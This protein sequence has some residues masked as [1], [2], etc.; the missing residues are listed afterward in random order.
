[1]GSLNWGLSSGTAGDR[2]AVAFALDEAAVVAIA[3][4]LLAEHDRDV[5][6][7]APDVLFSAVAHAADP[8][9]LAHGL[10]SAAA[11]SGTGTAGTGTAAVALV[12]L[13]AIAV[14][15]LAGPIAAMFAMLRRRRRGP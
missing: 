4:D 1:M 12:S 5:L 8:G 7:W 15:T 13:V 3:E 2:A 14:G 9:S 11:W 10:P 6:T